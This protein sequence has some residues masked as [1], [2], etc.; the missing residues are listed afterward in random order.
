[1]RVTKNVEGAPV[2]KAYRV[3][4]QIA[5]SIIYQLLREEGLFVGLSSGINLA[6][7]FD[8][9]LVSLGVLFKF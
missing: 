2:D 6:G 4:D 1:M 5:F 7:A 3:A 9:H 8:H